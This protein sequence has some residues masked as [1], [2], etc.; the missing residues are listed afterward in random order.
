MDSFGKANVLL[1]SKLSL[2]QLTDW[3][4]AQCFSVIGQCSGDSYRLYCGEVLRFHSDR[5]GHTT[6]VGRN[7]FHFQNYP[8]N[9]PPHD[10]I[11]T[12]K[13]MLETDEA[14]FCRAVWGRWLP[15]LAIL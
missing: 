10:L 6:Q 13:L 1:E 9:G 2:E 14:A 3:K 7:C 15:P 5:K 8:H 11:L 4:R 12:A